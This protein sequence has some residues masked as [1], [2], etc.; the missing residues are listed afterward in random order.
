MTHRYLARPATVTHVGPPGR[1][2]LIALAAVAAL[3]AV[4][5][6]LPR[7]DSSDAGETPAPVA[8]IRQVTGP[9]P[10]T[11]QAVTTTRAVTIPALPDPSV[12]S[13]TATHATTRAAPGTSSPDQR[14]TTATRQR[15]TPAAPSTA[16]LPATSR[17]APSTSAHPATSAARTSRSAPATTRR[18]PSTSQPPPRTTAP[19]STAAP[20]A[21]RFGIPVTLGDAR[22]LITVTASS[23]SATTGVLRAWQQRA[24]GTWVVAHGPYPAWLGSAGIGPASEYVSHTPQGTFTLTQ[25]FGRLANPRTALPYHQTVPDDWW[26]SDVHSPDYNTLQN[27]APASCPFNTSVSE[28]L[29]YVTPYY[30]YAVV[31]NVNRWPAVPGKGSAFFLHISPDH[32]PTAGCVAIDRSALVT[33]M[34]WLDPAAHPRIATGIG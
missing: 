32:Q 7:G 31:M 1:R 4:I 11:Q 34:R 12:P 16:S 17:V 27:C 21:P 29:Y 9:P 30:D 33:I 22:Q 5:I 20:P 28:H 15:P 18:A 19:R 3:A 14:R 2:I 8:A 24:D 6:G 23:S 10:P 25:A 13:S 26:V